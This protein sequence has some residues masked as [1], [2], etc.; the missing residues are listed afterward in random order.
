MKIHCG[1]VGQHKA[2]KNLGPCGSADTTFVNL[3][4]LQTSE[5]I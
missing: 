2:E 1:D 3:F 4:L 5:E